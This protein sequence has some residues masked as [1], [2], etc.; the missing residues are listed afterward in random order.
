M[1]NLKTPL[2]LGRRI[3]PPLIMNMMVPPEQRWFSADPHS[4]FWAEINNPFKHWISVE[5]RKHG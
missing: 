3:V 1:K 4:P 5:I 2:Y